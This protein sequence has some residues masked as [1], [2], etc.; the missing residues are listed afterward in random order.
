MAAVERK[1]QR[2]KP[3]PNHQPKADECQSPQDKLKSHRRFVCLE[4]R[5]GKRKGLGGGSLENGPIGG[6]GVRETREPVKSRIKG[7]I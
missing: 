7:G 6:I 5:N 3:L 1:A 4:G 2:D